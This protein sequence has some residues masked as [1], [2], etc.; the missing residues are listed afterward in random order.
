MY[1]YI[2]QQKSLE[3][4]ALILLH[5]TGGDE[6]DL[7]PVA[8]ILDKNATV[9]SLRGDVNE[10]GLLRFFK[11]KSEG[12][13]D[14][15]DLQQRSAQLSS[16]LQDIA[17]EKGFQ[18]SN[19]VLVGF[20]NGANMAISLLLR[21]DTPIRTALLFAPMYPVEVPEVDLSDYEIFI[22]SGKHDPIVSLEQSD[23]V[24]KIF[25]DKKSHVERFWVY[26]HEI[27]YDCLEAA[28]HFLKTTK[29][30]N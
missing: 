26:G 19:A 4:P 17:R 6:T 21:K 29:K 16:F 20:S 5:G 28:K 14:E 9:L 22:S 8:E 13:F 18:L 15:L 24:A 25:T 1:H 11:R 7:L 3:S 23:R 10:N 27:N 2:F 30:G 12:V